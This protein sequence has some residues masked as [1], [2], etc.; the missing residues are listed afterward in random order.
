MPK[1]PAGVNRPFVKT[2]I[3]YTVNLTMREATF[4]D[5]TIKAKDVVSVRVNTPQESF[6]SWL[7]RSIGDVILAVNR[8]AHPSR[9]KTIA[10]FAT[11]ESGQMSGTT[12]DAE[13]GEVEVQ[14]V[15]VMQGSGVGSARDTMTTSE[16]IYNLH[17]VLVLGDN[18][19]IRNSQAIR[20]F[21]SGPADIRSVNISCD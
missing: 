21:D 1:G 2:R 5:D 8:L 20:K 16:S 13:P 15:Y 18:S 11:S 9:H 17:R 7:K 12:I 10:E 19:P 4:L 3:K 6:T 14:W